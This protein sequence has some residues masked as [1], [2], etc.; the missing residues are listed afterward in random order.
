MSGGRPL[1]PVVIHLISASF[2]SP[3]TKKE[4]G[5]GFFGLIGNSVVRLLIAVVA[6]Y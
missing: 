1:D 6:L 5:S 4:R 3:R 2:P